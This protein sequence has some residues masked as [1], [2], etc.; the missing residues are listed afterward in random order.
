MELRL[1]R[2]RAILSDAHLLDLPVAEVA[3]RCGF[4]DP[5]HFAR[6]FRRQFGQSPLQF[7]S[8]LERSRH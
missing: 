6:R 4:A 5:S 8:N 2:A 1:A 3:A 7:R